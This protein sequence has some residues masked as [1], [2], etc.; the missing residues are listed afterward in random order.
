MTNHVT[1][2][3]PALAD[4]ATVTAAASKD[5][6]RP[7]LGLVQIT[8]KGD[9][10][11][12]RA[13]DSYCLAQVEREAVENGTSGDFTALLPAVF[14]ADVA[15]ATGKKVGRVRFEF[16]DGMVKADL[17]ANSVR[18]ST[19]E[20]MVEDVDF[21]NLDQV[22]PSYS[23]PGDVAGLALNVTLLA[24]AAKL[25]GLNDKVGGARFECKDSSRP[26]R[27]ISA[28]GRSWWLQMPVRMA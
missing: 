6:T 21:P 25:A 26:F 12:V 19:L 11:R 9:T 22:V 17:F 13:T 16:T 1:L 23:E 10:V 2:S 20:A 14:L 28:D 15:K 8:V 4:L 5:K 24:R 3:A 18:F 27:L 7:I